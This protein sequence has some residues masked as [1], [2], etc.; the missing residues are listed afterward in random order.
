MAQGTLRAPRRKA[1]SERLSVSE[2]L[3]APGVRLGLLGSLL[4]SIAVMTPGFVPNRGLDKLEFLRWLRALLL[5]GQ[6]G[7]IL[8]AVGAICLFWGWIKLRPAVNPRL[9]HTTILA[10]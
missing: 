7:R 4:I 5:F 8:L 3:R 10:R 1:S 2:V 9:P 6:I